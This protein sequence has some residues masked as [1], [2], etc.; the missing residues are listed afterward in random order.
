MKKR[1]IA[2]ALT[3][4]MLV[5]ATAC[6]SKKSDETTV[7]DETATEETS[8]VQE[9]EE[10]GD[11]VLAAYQALLDSQPAISRDNDELYDAS[12]DYDK[13]MELYGDHIDFYALYDIDMDDVPELITLTLINFRWTP[14]SI[15]TY[16]DGEVVLVQNPDEPRAHGTFEQQCTANGGYITYICSECHIHS[17]WVGT[18]PMDN[19]AEEDS[20][21]DLVRGELIPVQCPVGRSGVLIYFSDLAAVNGDADLAVPNMDPGHYVKPASTEP[22]FD[23]ATLPVIE[24]TSSNVNDGVWD[25]IIS[26]TDVGENK[27]PELSWEAV[28]GAGSYVLYMIDTTAGNWMHMKVKDVTTNSLALGEIDA[29]HYVGPYPPAG[30]GAHEYVVYVFAVRDALGSFMGSFNNT[31]AAIDY[32]FST[33]DNDANGVAGNVL[34]YG[35]VT[36]TFEAE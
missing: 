9:S 34:A 8:E 4:S 28:D 13:N 27:S 7:A 22:E 33:L 1:L 23:M 15:Y 36:G 21:Y 29:D 25:D 5:S 16:Q 31:N 18:D 2:T 12:F 14:V 24:V 3:M 6:S 35:T 26:N 30:S 19:Y 11:P 10:E 17:T 20:A 32:V